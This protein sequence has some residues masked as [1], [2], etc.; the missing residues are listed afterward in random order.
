MTKLEKFIKSNFNFETDEIV[1]IPRLIKRC[2]D[3]INH[4]NEGRLSEYDL[5]EIIDDELSII[6]S[7]MS[8]LQKIAN[9]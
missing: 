2:S 1:H 9:F 8:K 4:S 3:E 7:E 6:D 5:Y